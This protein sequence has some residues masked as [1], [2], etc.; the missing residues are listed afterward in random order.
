VAGED[1]DAAV[2]FEDNHLLVVC[3]PAGVPVQGDA[4]GDVSLLER[5][6]EYRR[7]RERKPGGVFLGLVHRLDRSV[8]G[9]TAFAKTSK[10]AARLSEQFR[11]RRVEKTYLACVARPRVSLTI[12]AEGLW[13][14]PLEKDQERNVASASPSGKPATTR[15]R[16]R[17]L[18]ERIAL[19]ELHPETGRPH[20]LRVHCA[21]HGMPIVGDRKYGSTESWPKGIALHAAALTIEHPTRRTPMRFE[22]PP[23]KCW[24]SALAR[25]GSL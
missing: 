19:L 3:K 16:V 23:P 6:K 11:A 5:F 25:F 14:E 4:T 9:V 21:H 22:C 15:F 7:T 13:D 18:A 2:L 20:Q 8:S 12:G 24:N 10:A 1:L 17:A